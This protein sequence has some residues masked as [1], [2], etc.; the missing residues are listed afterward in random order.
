MTDAVAEV[1][2]EPVKSKKKPLIIGLV[3]A[4]VGAGGGYF[5]VS[6]GLLPFGGEP[7]HGDTAAPAEHH[8]E[9]PE[10]LGDVG[11]VPLET[12]VISLTSAAHVRHLKLTAQL[13]VEN[14]YKADVETLLPR[15]LDVMNSYLRALDASD[16]ADPA[17][18]TRV[19]SQL[20]RRIQIVTGAGRVRDLLIMDFLL[21]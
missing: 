16:F 7:A 1:P 13:E 9:A 4:L 15:V 2:E 19:R 5:A 12:V 18:L 6:S 14:A 3:L 8:A 10:P 17:A 20:L 21:N 11:F